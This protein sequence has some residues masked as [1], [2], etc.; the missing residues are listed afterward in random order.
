VPRRRGQ[1]H[2]RPLAPRAVSLTVCASV[3][4]LEGWVLLGQPSKG[5]AVYG[6]HVQQREEERAWRIADRALRAFRRSLI[7]TSLSLT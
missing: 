7:D 5:G 4:L 3:Q 6:V 1:D 2:A